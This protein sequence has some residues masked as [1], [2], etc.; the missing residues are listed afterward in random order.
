MAL[1]SAD[2][3]D[4]DAQERQFLEAAARQMALAIDNARLYGS[5]V[6]ANTELRGEIE[7]R[8]R[9]EQTLADF[10][11]MVVHDLR[12]PLSNV[13]SMTESM[14]DGLFGGVNTCKKWLWKIE[15]N[16]RSL[17]DHVTDFWIFR[18]SKPAK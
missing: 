17:I 14:R 4:F 5:V 15:K 8:K 6:H 11:A 18:R 9:A 3:H 13:V 12:S 10:T 16:C 2:A 7:E 1:L